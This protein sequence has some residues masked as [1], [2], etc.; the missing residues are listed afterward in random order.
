MTNEWEPKPCAHCGRSEG[1]IQYVAVTWPGGRHFALWLHPEC[2]QAAL[3]RLEA[4]TE[5]IE[6]AQL[7]AFHL[8]AQSRKG[9]CVINRGA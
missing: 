4:P 9:G 8:R 7:D 6:P 2:E 5:E 1:R 3:S